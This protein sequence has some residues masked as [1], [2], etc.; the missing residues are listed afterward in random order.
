MPKKKQGFLARNLKYNVTSL[1][2]QTRNLL[3]KARNRELSQYGI[4]S[5]WAGLLFVTHMKRGKATTSDIQRWSGLEPHTISVLL[6]GMEKAGLVKKVKDLPA[7]N[8]FRIILTEKG[9]QI[10]Q[11]SAKRMSIKRI[12]SVLSK[13]QQ[14]ILLSLL[15]KVR[16]KALEELGE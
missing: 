15:V 13:E 6:T 9:E 11:Q 12:M 14:N 7:K 3:V 5:P 2:N 4:S 16:D 10:Y 8:R 1:I